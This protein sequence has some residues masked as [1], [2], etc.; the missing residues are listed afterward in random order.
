MTFIAELRSL[1]EFCNFGDTLEP[2]LCDRIVCGI[3]DDVLQKRLLAKSGLD[4]GKA[5][6]IALNLETTAQSMKELKSKPDGQASCVTHSPPQYQVHKTGVASPPQHQV[7]RASTTSTSNRG[8][9]GKSEPTCYRCGVRGRVLYKCKVYKEVVCHQCGRKGHLRRACRGS[10]KA[11]QPTSP[12]GT[13]QGNRTVY[14]V[15]EEDG[16]DFAGSPLYHVRSSSVHPIK[17][18]VKLEECL[19]GMEV[20]TGAAVSIMLETTFRQLWPN[21]ELYTPFTDLPAATLLTLVRLFLLFLPLPS[22]RA[23]GL[24]FLLFLPLPSCRAVGL[25]FLPLPS[26]HA[27]CLLFL[28]LLS[29]RAVGLLFL[30]LSS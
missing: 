1:A 2:I 11:S 21:R 12:R 6:E 28:P 19:V 24:L 26:C 7:H 13:N 3:N 27:V 25:L 30:L 10:W 14:Q 22:C 29:C 23:V 5:V 4:Y 18:Q 16:S 15:G 20:D 17:V 9:Q 8:S